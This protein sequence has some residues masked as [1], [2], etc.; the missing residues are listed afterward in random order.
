MSKIFENEKLITDTRKLTERKF[1]AFSFFFFLVALPLLLLFLPQEKTIYKFFL[2]SVHGK[3]VQ[4]F[5][6]KS[7]E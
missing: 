5:L 2:A 3:I 7:R 4:F 6:K 1:V